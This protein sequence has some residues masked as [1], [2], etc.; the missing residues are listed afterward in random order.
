MWA[1]TEQ[2]V[3]LLEFV[4]RRMLETEFKKL[5]RL[6]KARI[7]AGEN[8]H[9]R[10]AEQEISKSFAGQRQIFDVIL[11]LKG[12]EFLQ[13]VWQLL[14]TVHYGQ[15]SSYQAQAQKLGKPQAVRAVAFA[16]GRNRIAIII[17]CHR[18]I[19]KNGALM[20]YGGG[21]ARKQWLIE[22]EQRYMPKQCKHF[23]YK[24]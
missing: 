12:S 8:N 17:H 2:G 5:Q 19:G 24:A 14:Q 18:I 22:H 7:I 23:K 4:D 6:F 10:K 20:G 1:D 15:T 21:V 13:S 3:C 16:N 11:H 9:T